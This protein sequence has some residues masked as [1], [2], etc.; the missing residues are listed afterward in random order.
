[1]L[2]TPS[3]QLPLCPH[4]GSSG[5]GKGVVNAPSKAQLPIATTD[6]ICQMTLATKKQGCFPLLLWIK[7][8]S[9]LIM[10][11]PKWSKECRREY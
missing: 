9:N 8:Y 1:L 7:L 6:V 2:G 4:R 3:G 11:Q 5:T 10:Q